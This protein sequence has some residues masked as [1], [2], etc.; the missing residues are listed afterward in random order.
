MEKHNLYGNCQV[1]DPDGKYVCT[2]SDKKR[3]WYLN[4]GIAQ[5]IPET[6]NILLTFYPKGYSNRGDESYNGFLTAPMVNRCVVTGSTDADKLTK[7]HIVPYQFRKH[8]PDKYKSDNYHDVIMLHVEQ[9]EVYERYS[10]KRIDKIYS[11]HGVLCNMDNIR[12]QRQLRK[13]KNAGDKLMGTPYESDYIKRLEKNGLTY[14]SLLLELTQMQ[15]VVIKKPQH[16]LV[17]K[18]LHYGMLDAFIR[19]WR[20]HFLKIMKP[21]YMPQ[22]WSVEN[23][24]CRLD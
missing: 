11:D 7:H 23:P 3:S 12:R 8:M 9:H 21:K 10:L 24:C 20:R 14:D 5:P 22:G 16:E 17:D 18:L 15:S 19:D 1:L 6:D 13:L 4:K 2:V